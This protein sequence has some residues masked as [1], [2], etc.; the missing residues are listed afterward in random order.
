[1]HNQFRIRFIPSH[2]SRIAHFKAIVSGFVLLVLSL[3]A[4]SVVAEMYTNTSVNLGYRA[5]SLDWSIAGDSTGN[6]PNILSELSWKNLGIFQVGIESDISI[7]QRVYVRS[8]LSGGYIFAGEVQDSDYAGDNRTLEFSRSVNDADG[9]YVW[10]ASVGIGY[11]LWTV[12]TVVGR[13][14]RIIPTLGYSFSQQNLTLTNGNQV[15]PATGSFSDLDS[16]YTANWYGPWIGADLWFELSDSNYMIFRMEH[17]RADY[18]A[19]A[20]WNLRTEFQH[21]VS[22]EQETDDATGYVLS[23]SWHHTPKNEWQYSVRLDYQHWTAD[24]GVDRTFF[25]SV[26]VSTCGSIQCDTQLNGVNW[27][28]SAISVKARLPF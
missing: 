4:S 19:E 17:H 27:Q 24:K 7:S 6:N 15:I 5:D 21:P 14:L 9:G 23:F 11:E 3:A 22:F 8:N 1:M 28:S 2:L 16:T 26:G 20:D 10:D 13:H 12:D 25:N 18:F